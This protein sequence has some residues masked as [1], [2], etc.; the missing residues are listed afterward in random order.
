MLMTNKEIWASSTTFVFSYVYILIDAMYDCVDFF[1]TDNSYSTCRNEYNLCI[2]YKY[3]SSNSFKL[4]TL[5]I[6]RFKLENT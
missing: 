6:V 5:Y 2:L 1:H 3:A 4:G